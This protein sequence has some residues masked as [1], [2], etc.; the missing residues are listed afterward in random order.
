MRKDVAP[1]LEKGGK[2][3]AKLE[4]KTIMKS[5][6]TTTAKFEDQNFK[7]FKMTR[8][9]ILPSLE[10]GGKRIEKLERKQ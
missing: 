3:L 8:N 1:S 2:R 10:K 7:S 9:N 4:T 6:P 5:S